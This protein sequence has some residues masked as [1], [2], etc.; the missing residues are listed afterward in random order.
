MT[1]DSLRDGEIKLIDL[2][3]F[4]GI[5]GSMLRNNFS[6]FPISSKL[7]HHHLLENLCGSNVELIRL[8]FRGRRI[9]RVIRP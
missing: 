3:Q 4:H 8:L 6:G 5:G 1:G 2:I 7:A 9:R